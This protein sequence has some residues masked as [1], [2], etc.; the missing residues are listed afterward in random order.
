MNS[1]TFDKNRYHEHPDMVD[2]CK[3][4]IGKGGWCALSIDRSLLPDNLWAIEAMFGNTTY[5]FERREDYELFLAKW[6]NKMYVYLVF[7]DHDGEFTNVRKV[8]KNREDADAFCQELK[9]DACTFVFY[10]VE[11]FYV[12]DSI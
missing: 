6:E 10:S 8:F 11:R 1:V 3:A 12:H 7:E 9:D 2:W 5:S 4:N